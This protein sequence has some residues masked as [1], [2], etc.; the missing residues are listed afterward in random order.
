MDQREHGN[1]GAFLGKVLYNCFDW[2]NRCVILH[3]FCCQYK[4]ER[5]VELSLKAYFIFLHKV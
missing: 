5:E 4:H 2:F 3:F 1:G